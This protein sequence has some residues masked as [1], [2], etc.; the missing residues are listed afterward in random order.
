MTDDPSLQRPGGF[1]YQPYVDNGPWSQRLEQSGRIIGGVVT[2]RLPKGLN[3][4]GAM[5]AALVNDSAGGMA[6]K[7]AGFYID[8]ASAMEQNLDTFFNELNDYRTWMTPGLDWDP[9]G[10]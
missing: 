10:N 1:Y 4:V 2:S 9:S 6:G 7:T 8:N 3:L 5:V